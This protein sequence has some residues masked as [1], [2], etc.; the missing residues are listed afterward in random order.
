MGDAGLRS[1]SDFAT[2]LRLLKRL[3]A[4]Y[5]YQLK[6]VVASPADLDEITRNAERNNC[7]A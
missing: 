7:A 4:E 1:T 2:G 5:S 3:M 6:F